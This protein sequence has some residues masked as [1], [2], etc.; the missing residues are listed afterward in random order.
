MKLGLLN[1]V[2]IFCLSIFV[3]FITFS[4]TNTKPIKIGEITNEIKLGPFTGKR[5]LAVGVK[6]ILE[7]Y[8]QESGYEL[9]PNAEE[10]ISVKLIFFDVKN[11]GKNIGIYHNDASITE[12]IAMGELKKNGKV[13]KKTI[14]KGQSKEVSVSTLIV[15]D[16]GTF[17]QQTASIALK[18]VLEAII[19]DLSK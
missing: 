3:L 6:N 8:L 17:N 14:Q 1:I 16:D 7:E 9:D 2:K 18:K 19:K 15:A 12:I 10:E 11:I 13:I 5:N 4:D